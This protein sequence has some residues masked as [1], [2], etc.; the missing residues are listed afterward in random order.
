MKRKRAQNR[1]E[2]NG[3][4]RGRKIDLYKA[5]A[6]IPGNRFEQQKMKTLVFVTY[7]MRENMSSTTCEKEGEKTTSPKL[8]NIL[9]YLPYMAWARTY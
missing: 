5:V 7:G 6:T 2:E 1:R 9:Q 4:C 8:N 3:R